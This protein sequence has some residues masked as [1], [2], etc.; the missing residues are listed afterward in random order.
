MPI[1]ELRI[2]PP[3][4][5]ARLGAA[6]E[7]LEAFDLEA[8]PDHPLDYRRIVPR[9]SFEVDTDSGRIVRAYL[10]EKIRF[11]DENKKV[12]PVAPF[13]EVYARTSELPEQLQPLTV[14]LLEQQGQALDNLH[15]EV[16]LGNIKLF[17]R[18][19]N[20]EDQ[21][22]ARL[23]GLKDHSRHA[24]LGSCTNFLPGK[25]L[26]L[27]HVQFIA[28]TDEFPEIRLRYTPAGGLVYGSR[29]ERLVP[30]QNG[31]PRLTPD[32]IIDNEALVLYNPEKDWLGYTESTGPAL[33]NPAGIYA[34]YADQD[35][36]QVSWG[37]LDDECDGVVRVFLTLAD[38]SVLSAHSTI[39]AG[40]PAYAPDT[41]PVRVVSDELE[42]L[43]YGPEVDADSVS[44]DEATELVLRALE[45]VRLMNTAVMNGNPV[46]GRLNVAST[47]VRQ[48][49]NDFERYYEPIAASALVDNLALRALHERVFSALSAGGAPWFAQVMRQP[50]EI[51]D[52]SSTALRKMPALM[53]GADGRSLT[54]TRRHIDMVVKAAR[55]AMFS[56]PAGEQ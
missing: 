5:I 19:G 15:W 34:G 32:P 51:G 6:D 12:R 21:I 55:N 22:H 37:Y 3:L 41:L 44:L 45:T 54:L 42:Q 18:T 8:D 31:V 49:T 35:G 10:P 39:G 30:D 48:N 17:R 20:K 36:N 2:L 14:A 47:M 46:N 1:L 11:K 33:T 50:E 27:G 53:R 52:L 40:P 29:M 43:L 56:N 25:V 13:L 23:S 28:P 24:L 9:T 4:A 7:A 16:E 26:P 38:S